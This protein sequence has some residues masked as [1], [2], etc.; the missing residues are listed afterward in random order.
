MRM[1]VLF[2]QAASEL[3][4]FIYAFPKEV[5]FCGGACVGVHLFVQFGKLE[6]RV[7]DAAVVLWKDSTWREADGL[8]ADVQC[9]LVVLAPDVIVHDT[10]LCMEQLAGDLAQFVVVIALSP[11]EHVLPG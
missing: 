11:V 5:S 7:G 4:E 9:R 2:F 10:D 6:E 8:Q 1:G 3:A